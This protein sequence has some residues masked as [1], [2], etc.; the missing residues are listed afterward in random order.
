MV[1]HERRKEMA[2][3]KT[4]SKGTRGMACKAN[5]LLLLAHTVSLVLTQKIIEGQGAR[6]GSAAVNKFPL[7]ETFFGNI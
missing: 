2:T 6:A 4:N 1:K 7:A 5:S 3:D